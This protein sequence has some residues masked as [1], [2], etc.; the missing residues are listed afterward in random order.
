MN[1][2]KERPTRYPRD[3]HLHPPAQE[4]ACRDASRRPLPVESLR[5][6]DHDRAGSGGEYIGLTEIE[7]SF[8]NL[9][10]DLAIPA[11]SIVKKSGSKPTH[12]RKFFVLL[13]A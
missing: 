2:P 11:P 5:A 3:L 7:E 8:K 13:P 12:L 9:K 10:G 4:T 1:V 6:R